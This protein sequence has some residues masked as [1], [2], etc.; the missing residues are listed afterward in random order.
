MKPFHEGQLVTVVAE[1]E[2][3]DG[4]VVHTQGR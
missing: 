1:G 3:L 4:I 2:E